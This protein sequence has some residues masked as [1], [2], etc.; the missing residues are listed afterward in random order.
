MKMFKKRDLGLST[1]NN[2]LNVLIRTVNCSLLSTVIVY[3]SSID[4]DLFRYNKIKFL[5][6]LLIEINNYTFDLIMHFFKNLG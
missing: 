6:L 3:L 4:L 1:I 5:F 2:Q